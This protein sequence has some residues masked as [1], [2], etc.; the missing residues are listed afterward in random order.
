MD[1]A[2]VEARETSS[3]RPFLYQPTFPCNSPLLFVIPSEAEGSAVPRTLPGNVFRVL[4]GRLS[5]IVVVVPL[6]RGGLG[7][8]GRQ[9]FI[10]HCIPP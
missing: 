6:F 1:R 4:S 7:Q 8:H 10:P 5:I 3:N 2:V 9:R